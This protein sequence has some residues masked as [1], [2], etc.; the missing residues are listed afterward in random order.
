MNDGP[1]TQG[2][3]PVAQPIAAPLEYARPARPD[4]V[5]DV[6]PAVEA[7]I[8]E[9]ASLRALRRQFASADVASS[10]LRRSLARRGA[11][12]AIGDACEGCGVPTRGAVRLRWSYAVPT[13][14]S[15]WG[16]WAARAHVQTCHACCER[17]AGTIDARMRRVAAAGRRGGTISTLGGVLFLGTGCAIGLRDCA[18]G[19]PPRG[20][21]P[22]EFVF[23]PLGL[24]AIGLLGLGMLKRLAATGYGKLRV[25]RAMRRRLPRWLAFEGFGGTFERGGVRTV[26]GQPVGD[27]WEW[28]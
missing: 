5:P 23:V 16:G 15:P 25:P 4:E 27:D 26:P 20:K 13:G 22:W 28:R 18:S 14:V 21:D 24:V 6:V 11:A 17:C 10:Y 3:T 8:D 19:K 12:D 9:G 2:E 1:P 7:A